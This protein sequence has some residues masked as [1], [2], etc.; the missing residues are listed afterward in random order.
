[1]MAAAPLPVDDA[2]LD[3]EKCTICDESGIL[4]QCDEC[5]DWNHWHCVDKCHQPTSGGKYLCGKCRDTTGR[6]PVPWANMPILNLD[7]V[8]CHEKKP[9]TEFV[10]K[11]LPECPCNASRPKLCALC[12]YTMAEKADAYNTE[13]KCPTCRQPWNAFVARPTDGASDVIISLSHAR[14]TDTFDELPAAAPVPAE[15]PESTADDLLQ[16]LQDPTDDPPENALAGM[17]AFNAP[18]DAMQVDDDD[19]DSDYEDSVIG[20]QDPNPNAL[21]LASGGSGS[22]CSGKSSKPKKTIAK[23][24]PAS[25][26]AKDIQLNRNKASFDT[27]NLKNPKKN[28]P[29]RITGSCM[30]KI[31]DAGR[32][33]SHFDSDPQRE[34]IL[35]KVF[36]EFDADEISDP[37]QLDASA[38]SAHCRVLAIRDG[39][40][41]GAK[42]DSSAMKYCG[43]VAK[44]VS[45]T[46]FALKSEFVK[47][48]QLRAE[49]I[50]KRIG[51]AI[52][53]ANPSLKTPAAK[54]AKNHMAGF[55]LY[56]ALLEKED[57]GTINADPP[58]DMVSDEGE[59]GDSD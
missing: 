51:L 40:P 10:H 20:E 59:E 11:I 50:A 33:R 9:A 14:G 26:R 23:K 13:A 53:A 2:P 4:T 29:V 34:R 30:R 18:P 39:V 42:G 54:Y 56:C 28:P 12:A 46:G 24:G 52:V 6:H 47:G 15:E 7:C 49:G 43:Y 17:A 32:K 25:E 5:D 57:A 48:N 37:D 38:I 58:T 31:T 27:G 1:M 19:D 41:V 16:W 45:T 55:R 21:A 8:V 44:F 36:T 22:R 3:N 35:R